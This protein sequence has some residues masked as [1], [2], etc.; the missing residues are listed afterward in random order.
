MGLDMVYCARCEVFT[1]ATVKITD[2]CGITRCS[3]FGKDGFLLIA[4][5]FLSVSAASQPKRRQSLCN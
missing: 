2:F 1:T 5:K 4:G 3:L